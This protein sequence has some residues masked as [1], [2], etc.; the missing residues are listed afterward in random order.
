M[1]LA[2]RTVVVVGLGRSGIASAALCLSKG[3]RVIATDMALR[4]AARSEVLALEAQGVSLVFGGHDAVPWIEA[5]LVVVSPGVPSFS[6]ID[7]VQAS[8]REVIGELELASRFVTAPI[9]LV[10]GT[11]GKSTVTTLLGMMLSFEGREAFSGGNLGTPLAE[12]IDRSFASLVLEIS[13]FQAERIPT[14]HAKAAVLL[15]ITEDH[16]DR[17]PSFQAYADAKGNMFVGMGPGDT[18]VIPAAD[19]GCAKQAARGRARIVTFG[20]GG[21]VRLEAECLVDST[22]GWRVPVAELRIKGAHNELNACASMAMAAAMG[23]TEAHARQTLATFAGLAHRTVLVAEINGVRY[24]DDSKGTNVGASVAALR[25]MTEPRVVLIAGGRDK[26]GSYDPLVEVLRVKGRALV[27]L[28]EAADRLADAARG[29]VETVRAGSME[30]AVQQA[31]ALAKSGDAVLLSPACSSF[32]M[33][34][35]YGERGDVFARTVMAMAADPGPGG[36][37]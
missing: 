36:T 15:N 33:F 13:S 5:D 19:A 37:P 34:K 21:D 1:E 35:N 30:Q 11:N 3:A 31:A 28:G 24:F 32:D 22:T 17:Y 16:L 2:G 29:A 9:A 8:G 26:Q 18:A 14:L 23:A 7:A 25:G 4:E 27:V 10:G 12:V 6:Q 20:P